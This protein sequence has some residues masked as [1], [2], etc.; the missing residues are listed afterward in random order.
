MNARLFFRC[1]S[2]VLLSSLFANACMFLDAREQ[3]EQMDASCLFS[4]SVSAARADPHSIVV[5]LLRRTEERGTLQRWEIVDH[6]VLE[7]PGN[8]EFVVGGAKSS[9]TIAAFEDVNDDLVYQP[10]EPYGWIAGDHAITCAPG[11]RYTD[12][13]IAIPLKVENPFR[14]AVDIAKLQARSANAQLGLTLGQ[15]TAVGEVTSLA[16][17]RFNLKIAEDSLWRPLD[18]IMNVK[19]GI[20][21]LEP[22]DARKIPVLFVHGINGSPLNFTYLIEHLDRQRFQAWVYYYP[23]GLHLAALAEHLNQTLAKLELR[24]DFTRLAVVAHSMGG[25]VSRG[26]I[27]RN[28]LTA[29]TDRMPL[30]V[31]ISTPWAGDKAAELG[32][33]YAPVVVRVWTDMAPRSEYLESLYARP[34]PKDTVHHLVF[35]FKRSGGSGGESDDGSVTVAS[36][37]RLQAQREAARIYGFDDTH[38]SVLENPAL[39]AL[40]NDLL[41]KSF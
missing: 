24:Y 10:G 31:T 36:Q 1:A 11:G 22:Y 28:A 34:L 3:Q 30:Y 38:R 9:Y 37:L 32:V 19:P 25:L 39:T 23:S 20:Y 27:L 35:T 8:W 40:V 4:G 17:A 7:Q 26:F 16:D 5:I 21:F 15:R 41:A 29:T 33:K 14:Y 2:L 18:F 6:F 13:S 12:L